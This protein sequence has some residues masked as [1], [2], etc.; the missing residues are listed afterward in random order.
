MKTSEIINFMYWSKIQKYKHLENG[1][2]L[3]SNKNSF[4]MH[5]H[6]SLCSRGIFSEIIEKIWKPTN[7]KSQA[8]SSEVS[9]SLKMLYANIHF[10]GLETQ[11]ILKKVIK[12]L[13]CSL[14]FCIFLEF[15]YPLNAFA[16]LRNTLKRLSFSLR[17]IFK[18]QLYLINS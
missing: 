16:T 5:Y 13:P 17:K 1:K 10:Q 7:C 8:L 3:C 12:D 15:C 18:R 9:V 11:L 6:Y 2:F 4:I 14:R